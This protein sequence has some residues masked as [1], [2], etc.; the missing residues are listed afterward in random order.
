MVWWNSPSNFLFSIVT[1]KI[2]GIIKEIE[3]ETDIY[4]ITTDTGEIIIFP[5]LDKR[6][7][8]SYLWEKVS[9]YPDPP[10]TTWWTIYWIKNKFSQKLID[11]SNPGYF[12]F[13][14]NVSNCQP[15]SYYVLHA[16]IYLCSFLIIIFLWIILFRKKYK[17]KSRNF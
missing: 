5:Q 10:Y 3:T 7:E 4:K 15:W 16:S 17:N 8:Y 6:Q 9:L 2:H 14:T 11:N 1:C 13:H 12:S